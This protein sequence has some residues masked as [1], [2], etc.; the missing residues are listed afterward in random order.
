MHYMVWDF[1]DVDII[2]RK[3][4][5]KYEK[6][7]MH[8]CRSA[9]NHEK[10]SDLDVKM[11]YFEEGQSLFYL[12]HFEYYKIISVSNFR[13]P[14]A[15]CCLLSEEIWVTETILELVNTHGITV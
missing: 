13:E 12:N 7:L 11:M 8:D 3:L 5:W 9:T 10:P 6:Y 2:Y 15:G 4:H 1:I 14:F